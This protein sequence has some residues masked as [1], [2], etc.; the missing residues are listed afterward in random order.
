MAFGLSTDSNK[1]YLKL[2]GPYKGTN[3]MGA[4]HGSKT[5]LNKSTRPRRSRT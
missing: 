2:K 3:S 5:W 4:K 1:I